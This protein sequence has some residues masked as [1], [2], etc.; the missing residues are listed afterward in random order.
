MRCLLAVLAL[1]VVPAATAQ[2]AFSHQ[3]DSGVYAEAGAGGG[4][5]TSIGLTAVGTAAVGYQLPNGL[6]VGVH[7]T[8][9]SIGS[10]HSSVVVGPEVRYSHLLDPRTSLD[11]HASG[12]VGF[13][14]GSALEASG[15]PTTALGM[16]VGGSATRRFNLGRGVALATTG[17]LFGGV[18]RTLDRSTGLGITAEPAP[19]VHAYAGV[20][21][22][23]QI[24]FEALGGR[25]AIGP[26][27]SIPV[28]TTNRGIG[29]APFPTG[30][31]PTRGLIT[32]SF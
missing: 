11:L 29:A 3:T 24:E 32:F 27:G 20:T 7:T 21:V 6:A 31:G 19:D 1:A 15:Y 23:A 30:G 9:A 10:R 28:V 2:V 13:Y 8:V 17:G 26:Y 25:F 22:G 12:S 14:R 18:A 4:Y 5:G 16:E